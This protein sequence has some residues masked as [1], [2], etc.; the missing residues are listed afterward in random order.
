MFQMR[1]GHEAQVWKRSLWEDGK[2]AVDVE[3][4]LKTVLFR[5]CLMIASC[6]QG[7][8]NKVSGYLLNKHG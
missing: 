2:V 8:A 7:E 3:G 5:H 1:G 4:T 6:K